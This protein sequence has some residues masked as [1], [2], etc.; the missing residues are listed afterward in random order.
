[1]EFGFFP[2]IERLAKLA[3]RGTFKFDGRLLCHVLDIEITSL[4]NRIPSLCFC[5]AMFPQGLRVTTQC[6]SGLFRMRT[7]T[8][9]NYDYGTVCGTL[10]HFWD[11]KSSLLA[12]RRLRPRSSDSLPPIIARAFLWTEHAQVLRLTGIAASAIH[13]LKSQ[14]GHGVRERLLF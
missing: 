14:F 9:D 4:A 3:E 2:G 12:R 11:R 13:P 5:H 10:V 7:P 6:S 8:C 1:M